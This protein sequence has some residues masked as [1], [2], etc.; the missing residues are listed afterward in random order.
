MNFDEFAD[1]WRKN[2]LKIK[3]LNKVINEFIVTEREKAL[4]FEEKGYFPE[5]FDFPEWKQGIERTKY[6][7]E[8]TEGNET[9]TSK[10]PTPK[11]IKPAIRKPWKPPN[12]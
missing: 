9:S 6:V 2:Y 10:R 12:H 1:K 11:T 5:E 8:L 7:K 4:Y 3:N